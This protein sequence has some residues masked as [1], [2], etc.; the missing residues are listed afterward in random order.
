VTERT[1]PNEQTHEA[2]RAEAETHA[3]ADRLPTPEEEEI[4]DSL[5]VDPEVAKHEKDM[6]ERGAHQKGEGRIP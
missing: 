4:A 1:R 2:E 5:E 6:A 3:M